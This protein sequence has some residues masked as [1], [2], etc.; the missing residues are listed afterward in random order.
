MSTDSGLRWVSLDAST[1]YVPAHG[2][3]R[4]KIN[5]VSFIYDKV[6]TDEAVISAFGGSDYEVMVNGINFATAYYY[7]P[8]E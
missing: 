5:L 1:V 7:A 8:T 6:L 3:S 4:H 2:N